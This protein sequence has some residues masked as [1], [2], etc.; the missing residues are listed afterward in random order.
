[1]LMRPIVPVECAAELCGVSHKTDFEWRYRALATITGCQ[2]RFVL[3]DTF[4]IDETHM[5]DTDPSKGYE[6]VHKRGLSRQKPFV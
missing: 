3:C 1:M 4:W 6:Q 2:D 5:N